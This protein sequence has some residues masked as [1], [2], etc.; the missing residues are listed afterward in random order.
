MP[1][2]KKSCLSLCACLGRG[3]AVDALFRLGFD[4]RDFLGDAGF[5]FSLFFA[6]A[7]FK[8]MESPLRGQIMSERGW[9]VF[10]RLHSIGKPGENQ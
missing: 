2:M 9:K 8:A 3:R 10:V 5:F 1:T 4:G 7:F 6:L